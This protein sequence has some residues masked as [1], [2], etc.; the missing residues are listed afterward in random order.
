MP[1]CT[2]PAKQQGFTMVEVMFVV[3]VSIILVGIGA[4][5]FANLLKQNRVVG[6]VNDTIA[7]FQLARSE[8]AKRGLPVRL[9]PTTA[10]AN[11]D[12][13]SARCSGS[14][15]ADGVIAF[16]D[17]N[18]D[19]SRSGADEELV[20][21]RAALTEDI[22]VNASNAISTGITFGADGFPATLINA[23]QLVFCDES[24]DQKRRRVVSVSATGRPVTGRTITIEGG[25]EC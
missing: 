7:G 2:H 19:G 22:F 10:A 17:A 25:L 5:S 13:A 18:G 23:S 15:W 24:G 4:P 14:E 16:V 21:T 6:A 12:N 20:Y 1:N 3:A 11:A 9:C 8:A